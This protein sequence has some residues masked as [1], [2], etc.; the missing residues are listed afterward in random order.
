MFCRIE[1]T[2][3]RALAAVP[4]S[5][6]EIERIRGEASLRTRQLG[7]YSDSFARVETSV[8]FLLFFVS[9]IGWLFVLSSISF[10]SMYYCR[11][12]A[13]WII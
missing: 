7:D 5:I 13:L 9:L 2:T 11:L 10:F 6:R 3:T 12:I 8:G 1:T 4:R